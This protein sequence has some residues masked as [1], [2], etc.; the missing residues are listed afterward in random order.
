MAIM[1][2]WG[3]KTFEVSTKK[4]NPISNFATSTSMKED[5]SKSKKKDTELVS[6]TFDVNLH[7]AAG[8]SPKSEYESWCNLI[9]S[10]GILYL[11]GERFGR[12]TRL[13]KVG[14]SGVILDDFGRIRYGVLGLTFLEV[15]KKESGDK[16]SKEAAKAEKKKP[17]TKGKK[18]G[19]TV[20][21]KV[22]TA[23]SPNTVTV[24]KTNG[25]K[26]YID[27][28]RTWVNRNTLS[29]V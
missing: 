22:K 7:A 27:K 8:V 15:N 4:V 5:N 18:V 19:I 11:N 6:F 28:T 12:E 13:T 25:D 23:D 24:T 2:K 16:S 14:L 29:M 20:G 3:K 9:K 1:A 10:T 21:T 17:K 26:A